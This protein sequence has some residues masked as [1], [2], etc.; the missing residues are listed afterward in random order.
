M[1]VPDDAAVPPHQGFSEPWQASVLAI[2]AAMVRQGHFS[3][4]AW[5]D[6]LGAALREA[7]RSGAPDTDEAYFT[8]ALTAL[9]RLSAGCGISAAAQAERKAA[10]LEAYQST[11]HGQPVLLA[12]SESD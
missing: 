9:E 7:E 11:P 1:F 3:Q 12:G 6:A 8:A 4:V 5:A 10:W 2:A